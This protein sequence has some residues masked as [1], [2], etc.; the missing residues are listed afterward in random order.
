MSDA[1]KLLTLDQSDELLACS[2][3]TLRC[4][5]DTEQ[6]QA[7]RLGQRAKSDR[8]HPDEL[9]GVGPAQSCGPP[10]SL[11]APSLGPPPQDSAD[12]RVAEMLGVRRPD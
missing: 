2:S 8:I 12:D 5:T 10:L 7:C 11:P 9:D 6:L 3:R 4:A 1:G